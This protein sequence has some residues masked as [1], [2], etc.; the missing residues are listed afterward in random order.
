MR[1]NPFRDIYDNK[2]YHSYN[3]NWFPNIIDIE[4]TNNCNLSCNMC[5][6]QCMT[7]D[8]GFM[9]EDLFRAIIDETAP[10]LTP[11]RLIGW[12][13]PFLH[14]KII[15]FCKYAKVVKKITDIKKLT[16]AETPLHITTNGQ[17]ITE[18][19]MKELVNL[20]LDSIVFSMQGATKEGYEKMR[21]GSSYDKLEENIK[22]LIKIRGDKERPYIHISSTMTSETP[23]EVESFK[24]YWEGIVDS[25][26][27]G[28]TQ[29]VS[30]GNAGYTNYRPCTEVFHK[31]LIK[32][33]GRVSPCC[34]DCNNDLV[35]GNIWEKNIKQPSNKIIDIWKNNPILEAIKIL[36]KNN[37]HRNLSLCKNCLGAYNDFI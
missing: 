12:G 36:L 7:R 17:L 18:K 25:V 37:K 8:K 1:T 31:I 33:D 9:D 10:E 2:D 32:W 20:G 30:A 13:E 5:A 29:P 28:I 21:V 3:N 15:D 4:L 22:K 23:Q 34:N 19:Q 24:K 27:I 35:I 11:I 16:E 14:P 6:R 26:G